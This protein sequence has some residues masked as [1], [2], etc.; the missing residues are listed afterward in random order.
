MEHDFLKPLI[1]LTFSKQENTEKHAINQSHTIRVL[2]P[3]PEEA[4]SR[5]AA[6]FLLFV[7]PSSGT[8]AGRTLLIVESL[9]FKMRDGNAVIDAIP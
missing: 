1:F 2:L 5:E 7:M 3:L 8:L 6:S 9:H 4:V